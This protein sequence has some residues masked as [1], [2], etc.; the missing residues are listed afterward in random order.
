MIYEYS[1]ALPTST[2]ALLKDIHMSLPLINLLKTK[3]NPKFWW[4]SDQQSAF[5]NLKMRFSTA[6]ILCHFNPKLS[7][8]LHPN[9]SNFAISGILSWLYN[10]QQWHP[11]TYWSQKYSA[12]EINYDIYDKELLTIVDYIKH[13]RYYLEGSKRPV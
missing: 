10:D 6:P 12:A 9:A 11:I 7:I 8:R 1:L 3:N 2:I 4:E 13:W 5:D